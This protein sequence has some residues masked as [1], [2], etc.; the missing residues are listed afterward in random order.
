MKLKKKMDSRLYH[1]IHIV[2]IFQDTALK[3]PENVGA[4]GQYSRKYDL[5][6][7]VNPYFSI[8]HHDIT[9]ILLKVVL[10]TIKPS[11]TLM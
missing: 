7:N 11:I 2:F 1:H 9:E 10:N 8:L 4:D 3:G 6:P 5:L